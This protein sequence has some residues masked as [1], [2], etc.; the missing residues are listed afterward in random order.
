VNRGSTRSLVIVWTA[1]SGAAAVCAGI[2][3]LGGYLLV[4]TPFGHP[5]LW[6][7]VGGGQWIFLR[8]H[9]ARASI[10]WNGLALAAVT[11]LG[12]GW[13]L[14]Q[15]DLPLPLATNLILGTYLIVGVGVGG[16]GVGLAQVASLGAL[17]GADGGMTHVL[18]SALGAAFGAMLALA[19]AGGAGIDTASTASVMATVSAAAGL[20]G[21][22]YGLITGWSVSRL[23]PAAE[24]PRS[25]KISAR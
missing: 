16:A 3:T 14:A 2:A 17:G 21:V 22:G 1:I 24:A 12:V 4:A 25:G 5:L 18:S 6:G 19:V 13:F 10:Y 15:L 20:G 9:G 7:L 23:L 8:R 11:P